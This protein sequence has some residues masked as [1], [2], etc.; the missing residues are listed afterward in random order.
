MSIKID[1]IPISEY[2]LKCELAHDHPALSSTRDYSVEIPGMAGSYD[3][4]SD[5]GPKPFNLPMKLINVNSN[6]DITMALDKFKKAIFDVYGRPKNFELTFDYE[7]DRFY[8]ARYSGS[9][10]IERLFYL[11]KFTLPLMSFDPHPYSKVTNDEVTW[12]SEDISFENMIYTFGHTGGGEVK[13]ITFPQLYSV[14]VAGLVA[15]PIITISGSGTNVIC[16]ANGKSFSLGTFANTSWVIDG[17]KW[18]VLKNGVNGLSD[19][20]KNYPAGDWLE[21][22]PGDNLFYVDGTSLNITVQVKFRDKLM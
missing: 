22:F 20:N 5:I 18:T 11:G 15:K 8:T 3:F 13:T 7:N 2:N 16:S 4:G 14:F 17:E 6:S 21:F 9:M 19:Y 1:G 10:P 12:G